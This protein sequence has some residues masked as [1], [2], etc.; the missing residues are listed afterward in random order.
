MAKG[1]SG[2][3]CTHPGVGQEISFQCLDDLILLADWH[4]HPQGKADQS[5][6]LSGG[7]RKLAMRARMAFGR[8]GG[9]QGDV[10]EHGPDIL[11]AHGLQHALT[12]DAGSQ[13]DVV[14][15]SIC[16]LL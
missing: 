9:M 4:V 2:G 1:G 10:V 7:D 5:L 16:N 15:R 14:S 13:Q 11:F 12:I 8:G 6:G 3:C